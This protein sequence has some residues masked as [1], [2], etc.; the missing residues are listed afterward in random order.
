MSY[1]PNIANQPP[2]NVQLQNIETFKWRGN[3]YTDETG[4]RYV[5]RQMDRNTANLYDV[6]SYYQALEGTI[7]EPRLMAVEEKHGDKYVIRRVW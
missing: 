5:H 3:E 7:P 4:K 6:E 1:V 2:D